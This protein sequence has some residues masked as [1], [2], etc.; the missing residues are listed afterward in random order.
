MHIFP[1]GKKYIGITSTDVKTR[2]GK[3]GY[4][5]RKQLVGR[6]IKKYGWDN[7]EHVVIAKDLSEEVAKIGEEF[8]IYQ[9][10]TTNPDFGYNITDGGECAIG[11]KHT[12]DAKARMS[13]NR[14]G[15]KNYFYGQT[16]EDWQREKISKT[17]K[18][19]GDSVGET[20]PS[21][22][23]TESDVKY[24]K[25]NYKFRDK[26]FSAVALGKKFNVTPSA[27]THVVNGITWTHVGD[28]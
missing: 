5:Y 27:I 25:A 12:E 4:K 20:N 13:K 23:L 6:A 8:L 18:D 19:K 22:K 26:N 16:M 9:F 17:K 3:N 24:I 7:V 28:E 2:W 10:D 11:Y 21:A 15:E 14:S 1:N